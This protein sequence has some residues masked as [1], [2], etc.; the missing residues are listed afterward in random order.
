MY[1]RKS[2]GKILN[3]ILIIF[4]LGILLFGA[5]FCIFSIKYP[6]KYKKIIKN[7][8]Q[9]NN[10]DPIL[11]FSLINAESSFNPSKTSNKGAIGLMQ[12]M[13]STAIFIATELEL[14]NFDSKSLYN[15]EVNIK[16][17]TYYLNYL[18]KKYDDLDLVICAYNAGETNVNSWLNDKEYSLDGKKL[19]DIP[20]KETKNYLSKIKSFYKVYKKIL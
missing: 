5:F 20:F 2:K 6:V 7:E 15:P 11:V 9:T 8:C 10:L 12:I 16:F 4:L 19:D 3:I 13:P 1:N 18:S 14:D 17:G